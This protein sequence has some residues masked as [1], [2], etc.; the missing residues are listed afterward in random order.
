MYLSLCRGFSNYK[1]SFF[2]TFPAGDRESYKDTKSGKQKRRDDYV[3]TLYHYAT[4]SPNGVALERT[5]FWC[6]FQRHSLLQKLSSWYEV[7]EISDLTNFSIFLRIL[8]LIELQYVKFCS[9]SFKVNQQFSSLQ[10]RRFLKRDP[11][12]HGGGAGKGEG[13][14]EKGKNPCQRS[15]WNCKGW[16][17]WR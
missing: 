10:S 9:F 16:W 14:E 4:N 17:T 13:R 2:R 11:D 15:L 5:F 8:H 7:S 12:A 3:E 6:R 1:A